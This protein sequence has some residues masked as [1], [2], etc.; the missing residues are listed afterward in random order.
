MEEWALKTFKTIFEVEKSDCKKSQVMYTAERRELNECNLVDPEG[1]NSS[2]EE[3]VARWILTGEIDHAMRGHHTCLEHS[4]FGK[5]CITKKSIERHFRFK[6]RQAE[7]KGLSDQPQE[8]GGGKAEQDPEQTTPKKIEFAKQSKT[9][10][11]FGRAVK[12]GAITFDQP[13][14]CQDKRNK[15]I[16]GRSSVGGEGE[17]SV[18]DLEQFQGDRVQQSKTKLNFKIKKCKL[19][20][21]TKD[22]KR[23]VF[24]KGVKGRLPGGLEGTAPRLLTQSQLWPYAVELGIVDPKKHQ[25]CTEEHSRRLRLLYISKCTSEAKAMEAS[26][27]RQ[28]LKPA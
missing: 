15:R 27:R 28:K 24:L 10:L 3:I 8:Q 5:D 1:R 26:H 14:S 13:K 4:C 6:L 11:G 17:K 12:Q 20:A 16:K 21:R 19:R 25:M 22:G 23:Y 18:V 7:Q 9:T 2:S